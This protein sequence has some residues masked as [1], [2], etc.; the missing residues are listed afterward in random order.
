MKF[1]GYSQNG[2]QYW[3]GRGIT[4]IKID[5]VLK[6]FTFLKDMGKCRSILP[7]RKNYAYMSSYYISF[8]KKKK[9]EFRDFQQ[10]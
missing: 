7:V 2:R 3:T 10:Y 9:K 1:S 5:L 6:R 4:L 8:K